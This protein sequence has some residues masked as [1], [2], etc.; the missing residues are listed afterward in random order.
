MKTNGENALI[1][2][3]HSLIY[4]CFDDKTRVW[5]EDTE[6]DVCREN[7]VYTQNSRVGVSISNGTF[8]L[9][10]ILTGKVGR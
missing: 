6:A 5:W 9:Y 10:Y 8:I 4:S 2:K 3:I 7:K 1:P